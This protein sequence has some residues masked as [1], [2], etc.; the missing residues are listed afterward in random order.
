MD[1]LTLYDVY[2]MDDDI[3]TEKPATS[4][5]SFVKRLNESLD[6]AWFSIE[7]D[8][9]NFTLAHLLLICQALRHPKCKWM[10]LSLRNCDLDDADAEELAE[11]IIDNGNIVN[12]GLRYNRITD[13]GVKY[14]ADACFACSSLKLVSM[15]DN[16]VGFEGQKLAREMEILHEFTFI[17]WGGDLSREEVRELDRYER[18][19]EGLEPESEPEPK[20]DNENEDA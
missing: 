8:Y 14:F 10:D 1:P 18:E 5:Q 13:V 11:A 7:Q 4:L 9:E 12:L 16:D 20:S 15:P 19:L 2:V 3:Y 17:A 6:K